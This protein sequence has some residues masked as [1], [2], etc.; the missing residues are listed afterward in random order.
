MKGR[1]GISIV[2]VTQGGIENGKTVRP[3]YRFPGKTSYNRGT[4][5]PEVT[6]GEIVWQR[7]TGKKYYSYVTRD[8][9][10]IKANHVIIPAN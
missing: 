3:Y 1:P 8:D 7:R 6:Y 9:G 10:V 4:A 5:R 2:G